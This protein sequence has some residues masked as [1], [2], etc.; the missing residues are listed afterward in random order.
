MNYKK[1]LE[2]FFKCQRNSNHLQK[3]IAEL[4]KDF[5][6]LLAIVLKKH[7]PQLIFTTVLFNNQIKILSIMEL[8]T[9]EFVDSILALEDTDTK[10]PIDATFA[11]IVL[12][13]SDPTIFTADT[14]VNADGTIDIVGVA[15]GTATLNVKADATYIDGNT[16]QSVT[17]T[18]EANIPV[19][20]HAPL[21]GAENTDLVVTFSPAQPV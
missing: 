17:A 20:V 2:D 10:A 6:E 3:K 13:S 4:E 14:D 5:K 21:P 18:K 12:T 8:N 1:F 15:E 9:K 19:T 7:E 11:N 16:K